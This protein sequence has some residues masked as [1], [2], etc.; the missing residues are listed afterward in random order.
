M[1]D[2]ATK[3]GMH[4][5][6]FL[7]F[8][9]AA[10]AAVLLFERVAQPLSADR[11]RR[12]LISR[13]HDPKTVVSKDTFHERNVNLNSLRYVAFG[14]SKTWGADLKDREHE[15]CARELN[16]ELDALSYTALSLSGVHQ[17]PFTKRS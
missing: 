11:Q 13:H 5:F 15:V 14:T 4:V 1:A 6:G 7:V 17:A 2:V 9:L 16:C 3:S 12:R 8:A 10:F